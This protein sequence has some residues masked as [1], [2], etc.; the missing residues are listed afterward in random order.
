MPAYLGQHFLVDDAIAQAAVDALEPK[1]GEAVVEIGPGR[2]VLTRKLIAAGV[3]LTA[4]ELD[5]DMIGKLRREVAE[6]E[7][8]R[9]LHGDFLRWRMDSALAKAKSVKFLA[10]FMFQKEVCE[11]LVAEPGSR[12]YGILSIVADLNAEVSWVADAPRDRFRPP[13]KVDSGVLKFRMR[14]KK[15]PQGV[16]AGALLK[17][18]K[19]AFSQRRKQIANPLA[20]GLG[21]DKA[22]VL[23]ALEA[24]GVAPQA[25]AESVSIEQFAA[26]S[27]ASTAPSS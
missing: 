16:D 10:V 12:D 5:Q 15:L 25:R 11:R 7:R 26:C 20:H 14:S 24:A 13:P 6:G 4:V 8:F 1:A 18:A 27:R 9:I 3:D 2:G 21:I 17:V 23:A 19:A 22:K